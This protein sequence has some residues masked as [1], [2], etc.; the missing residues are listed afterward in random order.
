MTLEQAKQNNKIHE[1]G[2]LNLIVLVLSI[3]ILGALVV[4]TFFKLNAE[5]SK[6]LEYVDSVICIFFLI[7]FFVR[8]YQAESKATFLKWGWVDLI[9]SIPTFN[10][11]RGA[12]LLRLIRLLR[13]VRTFRTTEQ[14]IKHVYRNKAKGAFITV[15]IISFLLITFSSIAILQF[16]TAPNSNIKTAEDAL[17]WSYTTFTTVGYGDMYPVTG[18]GRIIAVILMTGGVGLFGTFSGF[19]ASWFLG[20]DKKEDSK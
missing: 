5:T 18:E 9:A 11:F 12:R 19:I 16:E 8:L 15:S 20:G 3:Y 7:E 1:F 14:F 10:Y 2:V 13:I 17:W 4:D 6:I